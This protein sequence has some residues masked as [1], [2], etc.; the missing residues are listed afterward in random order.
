MCLLH[1]PRGRAGAT[2]HKGEESEVP[3]LLPNQ[4]PTNASCPV[5]NHSFSDALAKYKS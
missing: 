4:S 3:A 1:S 2:V 5:S